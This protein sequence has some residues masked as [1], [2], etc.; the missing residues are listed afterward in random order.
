MI[1]KIFKQ[2]IGFHKNY[3]CL[4]C[5]NPVK[6][7]RQDTDQEKNHISKIGLLFRIYKE[8]LKFNSQ[9]FTKEAIQLASKYTKQ[10]LSS[11]PTREMQLRSY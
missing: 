3:K 5:K 4:P 11:L 8:L 1:H 9:N 10:C 7:E 6:M 2:F